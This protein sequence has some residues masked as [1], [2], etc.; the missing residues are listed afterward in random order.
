MPARI[1]S[2]SRP[3]DVTAPRNVLLIDR[4]PADLLLRT[5]GGEPVWPVP[6]DAAHRLLARLAARCGACLVEVDGIPG[7]VTPADGTVVQAPG[8]PEWAARLYGHLTRRRV[9]TLT[10]PASLAGA[11]VLLTPYDA[12]SHDLLA[13]LYRRPVTDTYPGIVCVEDTASALEDVLFHTAAACLTGPL[14]DR[15]RFFSPALP[16]RAQVRGPA[17]LL[18]GDAAGPEVDAFLADDAACKAVFTH[19]D[20]V[21]AFLGAHR[22]LCGIRDP[23]ADPAAP[24]PR[25]VESGHCHRYGM[26]VAEAL[27]QERLAPPA[28]LRAWLFFWGVCWGVLPEP[29]LV[30]PEWSIGRQMLRAREVPAIATTW[31]VELIGPELF[32]GFASRVMRGVPIGPALRALASSEVARRTRLNLCLL[33]DPRVRLLAPAPTAAGTSPP[34]RR[35]PAAPRPVA[36]QRVADTERL[37]FLV[38]MVSAGNHRDPGEQAA[39]QAFLAA[40]ARYG[41]QAAAPRIEKLQELLLSYISRSGLLMLNR[42]VAEAEYRPA[43]SRAAAPC[44]WCLPRHR[45]LR[46]FSG[47]VAGMPRRFAICSACGVVEDVPARSAVRA[48]L[49]AS[50]TFRLANRPRVQPWAGSIV[51]VPQVAAEAMAL[52]W[53]RGRDDRP[54]RQ[55]SLP[56]ALPIGPLDMGLVFLF[57]LDLYI[58]SRRGRAPVKQQDVP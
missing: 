1:R 16:G 23:L 22:S 48:S 2:P 43:R 7:P 47:K 55:A 20:G 58:L 10:G 15:V 34:P 57:G 44:P 9:T 12:L 5:A 26:S 52:C 14:A 3:G 42:W 31:T 18:G 37:A 53:P 17:H 13:D 41:S 21:D 40:A 36:A 30:G 38:Q 29:R 27:R 49:D 56:A 8:A 28:K 4:N 54:S 32:P 24:V 45:P 25:C 6:S 51:I 19:S 11:S 35:R 46:R 33:G 50:G 39:A